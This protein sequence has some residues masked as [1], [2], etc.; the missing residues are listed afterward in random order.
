[1]RHFHVTA[2]VQISVMLVG[3][4]GSAIVVAAEPAGEDGPPSFVCHA[5]LSFA[6]TA[7]AV[8]PL[9]AAS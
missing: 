6:G 2:L 7:E 3:L 1:M 8:W 9:R 4:S 5:G